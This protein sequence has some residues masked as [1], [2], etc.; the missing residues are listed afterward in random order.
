MSGISG[1]SRRRRFGPRN[2]AF[3]CVDGAPQVRAT[4]APAFFRKAIRVQD[5]DHWPS[6]FGGGAFRVRPD[7]HVPFPPVAEIMLPPGERVHSHHHHHS[8][9]YECFSVWTVPAGGGGTATEWGAPRYPPVSL[10][11]VYLSANA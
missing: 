1:I 3:R 10:A 5:V 9:R 8:C 11:R 6:N 4:G 2:G 7:Y